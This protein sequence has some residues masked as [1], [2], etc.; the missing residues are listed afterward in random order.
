MPEKKLTIAVDGYSSCGKSTLAK[1][2]AKSLGYVFIDSGAMYRGVTLYCMR[3]D[4]IEH[5]ILHKELIEKVLPEIELHFEYNS[6]NDI[7]E[8]MLNG[9]NVEKEIRLPH[10]AAN[11]SKIATLKCVRKKLVEAQRKMGSEGGV[12]MDG[13]D[14]G[15]VV[16]PNADLK[17]FIT[18]SPEIRAQRRKSELENK[19]INISMDEVIA[20]L[21]ERDMM[22]TSRQESPLIQLD[23]AVVIDTSHLTRELQLLEALTYVKKL[24]IQNARVSERVKN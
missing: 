18:A 10:V 21:L 17:F 14:I 24:R 4:L 5:E 12:V 19:G 6:T 15:S 2:L 23:E 16:F 8:L 1:A 20:N 13:R 3:H 22:D 7:S 11:V 9:E